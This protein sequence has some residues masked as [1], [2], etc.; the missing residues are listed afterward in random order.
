[1][2]QTRYTSLVVIQVILS[3]C[4]TSLVVIQVLL[5]YKPTYFHLYNSTEKQ[6]KYTL[7]KKILTGT[8][9]RSVV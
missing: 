7:F 2:R 3:C 6:Y 4:Y 9:R 8:T 5:L 1:M